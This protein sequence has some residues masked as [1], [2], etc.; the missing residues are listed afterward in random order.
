[1]LLLFLPRVQDL[2][3]DW[4]YRDDHNGQDYE[5]EV[6]LHGTWQGAHTCENASLEL[7]AH[8]VHRQ[9]VFGL[10]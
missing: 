4:K 3:A 6:F 2:Y 9:S 7:R 8:P 1:M 5:S 10:T